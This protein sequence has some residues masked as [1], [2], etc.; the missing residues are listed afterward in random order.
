MVGQLGQ[1]ALGGGEQPFAV[2]DAADERLPEAGGVTVELAEHLDPALDGRAE[3]VDEGVQVLAGDGG[4][5][6]FGLLQ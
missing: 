6:L 2:G 4:Q 3:L 1:H 5:E